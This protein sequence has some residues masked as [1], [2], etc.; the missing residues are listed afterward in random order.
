MLMVIH[1]P[2]VKN[3]SRSFTPTHR[4]KHGQHNQPL[5][6][7]LSELS[8]ALLLKTPAL[9]AHVRLLH[10]YTPPDQHA[11]QH[12]APHPSSWRCNSWVV[13]QIP[14]IW[15]IQHF[16]TLLYCHQSNGWQAQST[17]FPVTWDMLVPVVIV[18]I[19]ER[20]QL[21]NCRDLVMLSFG[22]P[23][24][25]R[26]FLFPTPLSSSMSPWNSTIH[27]HQGC[28]CL[29]K[30]LKPKRKPAVKCLHVDS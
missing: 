20:A 14:S 15:S 8:P 19:W 10:T 12:V 11:W 7:Y 23:H 9:L 17:D 2:L 27:H 5:C 6:S 3:V 25:K 24:S 29:S 30:R 18:E 13:H 22:S 28:S 16:I 21:L 26:K 4:H 1:I